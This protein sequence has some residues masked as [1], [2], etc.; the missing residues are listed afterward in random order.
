M[1]DQP[2][3]DTALTPQPVEKLSST[4]SGSRDASLDNVVLTKQQGEG[5][6]EGVFYESFDRLSESAPRNLILAMDIASG[7][8]RDRDQ[9]QDQ[10]AHLR[11][12]NTKLEG[13]AK[14]RKALRPVVYALNTIGAILFAKGL[15]T[16]SENVALSIQ[17]IAIGLVLL[18]LAWYVDHQGATK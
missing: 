12:E 17:E 15:A 14:N 8:I 7:W 4:Q 11:V 5:A 13:E 16:I 2:N 18:S 3:S 6:R 10:I 9:K 1:E